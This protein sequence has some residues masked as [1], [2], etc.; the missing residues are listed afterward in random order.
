MRSAA[1]RLLLALQAAALIVLTPLASAT[2]VDP[3]WIPGIYD[4]ADYDDVVG[5]R[6]NG[7]AVGGDRQA[8]PVAST[9]QYLVSSVLPSAIAASAFYRGGPRSPPTFLVG[10]PDIC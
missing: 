8:D 9:A 3:P 2:P 5:M 4:E 10:H 6:L 7:L 1:T